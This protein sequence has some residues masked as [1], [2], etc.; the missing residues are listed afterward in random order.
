MK[1]LKRLLSIAICISL[2][3]S[4]V[5]FAQ[6][7][8]PPVDSEKNEKNMVTVTVED[9]EDYFIL[10]SVP[11]SEAESYQKRLKT[12]KTFK[13]KEMQTA[14]NLQKNTRAY[15]P[16]KI[17]YQKNMYKSSIEKAVDAASGRGSFLKW[18]NSTGKVVDLAEILSLVKLAH[19]TSIFLFVVELLGSSLQDTMSKQEKWWMTAYRDII[20][21]K[22]K[23]VR[24]TIIENPTE[25]PK[26]WRV[27]ERI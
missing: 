26:I 1:K 21:K 12:D 25:Y 8:T 4:T 11:K 3:L 23:A 16:G 7:P 17:V 13:E 24:Y 20:N 19:K 14:L 10:V 6:T 18:L 22:I 2:T 15:P 27:F 5:S 9:T